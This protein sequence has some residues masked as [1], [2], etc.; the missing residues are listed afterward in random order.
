MNIDYFSN[1]Y[2]ELFTSFFRLISIV[3]SYCLENSDLVVLHQNVAVHFFL[4]VFKRF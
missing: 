4:K 3:T 1:F 2:C